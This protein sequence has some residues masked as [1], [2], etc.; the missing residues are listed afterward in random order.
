MNTLSHAQAVNYGTRAI[1]PV[2][3]CLTQS[4]CEDCEQVW[5]DDA[6]DLPDV[7]PDCGGHARSIDELV[8]VP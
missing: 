7:C 2:Y 5:P 6:L 4:E 1:P 3:E 8:H